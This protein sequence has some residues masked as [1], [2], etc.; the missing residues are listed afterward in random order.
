MCL[1]HLTDVITCF[2]FTI[3]T[4]NYRQSNKAFDILVYVIT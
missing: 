2:G 3:I 1:A 4:H